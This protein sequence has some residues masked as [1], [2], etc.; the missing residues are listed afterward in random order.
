VNP[1]ASAAP[2][3][4]WLLLALAAIALIPTLTLWGSSQAETWRRQRADQAQLAAVR[5]VL[6]SAV[7]RWHEPAWQR[8][9][10]AALAAQHV[11]AGLVDKRAGSPGLAFATADG[12]RRL[13]ALGLVPALPGSMAGACSELG[14]GKPATLAGSG[15]QP[16]STARKQAAC[17]LLGGKPATDV[18]FAS[19]TF[20]EIAILDPTAP[21][22]RPRVQ[23]IADLWLQPPPGAPPAWLPEA[24]AVTALLI[25]LAAVALALGRLVVRPLAGMSGAARQ[26]AAGNLEVRLPHSAAREVAEV[27]RA[28]ETMSAGLREALGRQADLEQERRLFISAIAHDLRTPLF[29]LTGYLDGLRDGLARTPEKTEHYV[30]VCREQAATL[31]RL[32]ADLFA[33]ARMEYL[34][35]AIR[36][37]PLELGAVLRRAA[38]HLAPEAATRAIV[39]DLTGPG[40]P[41][42]FMGD[43]QLMQRAVENLLD[44][45]VQ[46]TPVGGRISVRWRR[47][48]DQLLFTIADSGSGI[49]A[50]DLPHLFTPL[51]R[52]AAS[53]SRETGGAGLGLSIA[54]RIVEVHGGALTA[55]NGATGG[56]VFTGTLPASPQVEQASA[57][58]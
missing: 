2:L 24:G 57:L 39:I 40:A 44:N 38:E 51:Y 10:G 15:P 43:A 33:Y 48:E 21:A 4:L 52:G 11:E 49:S 26:I 18:S 9:A 45:A 31:E 32:V 6:G 22:S 16:V 58:G 7:A 56:A 5:R 3:R 47:Q 28:L 1:R 30:A 53:R 36:R 8:W 34:E 50:D 20:R 25:T 12:R 37:E 23:G 42:P 14:N 19:S 54:R 17:G 46:Y 27:A 29:T 35:Q 13:L 41:G 55:A